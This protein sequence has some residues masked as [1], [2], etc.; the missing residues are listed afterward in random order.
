VAAVTLA[1]GY[2][3]IAVADVVAAVHV[4]AAAAFASSGGVP[5]V[6]AIT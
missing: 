4:Q 5:V 1:A 3:Q 2:A 6:D